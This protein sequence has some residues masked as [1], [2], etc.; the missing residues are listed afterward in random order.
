MVLMGS[1]YFFKSYPDFKPHDIDWI[2]IINTNDFATKRVVRGQ[3]EDYIIL[4]NKPKQQLI[5]DALK[6]DLAMVVGKFLIPEFNSRIGFTIEDLPQLQPLIDKLDEKHLYEKI[7]YEA[8]LANG[9]FIL[10]QEQR[11]AAYESYK[12]IRRA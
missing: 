1:T 3:G 5:A 4:K 8:Y 12:E 2:D 9:D 6:S 10:T 7:I 11:N